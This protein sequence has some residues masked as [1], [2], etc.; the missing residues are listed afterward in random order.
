MQ[1]TLRFIICITIASN[2]RDYDFATINRIYTIFLIALDTAFWNIV[3]SLMH[4]MIMLPMGRAACIM[5]Y[6]NYFDSRI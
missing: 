6:L 3:L 5:F 1:K 4:S 2:T